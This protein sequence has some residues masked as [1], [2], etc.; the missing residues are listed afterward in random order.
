MGDVVCHVNIEHGLK[1]LRVHS[2]LRLVNHS[3]LALEG[4]FE[5]PESEQSTAFE[6]D[7]GD[8]QFAP[9]PMIESGRVKIF[10][11]GTTETVF[12][13]EL[14]ALCVSRRFETLKFQ[15]EDLDCF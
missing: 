8:S 2:I 4:V 15:H 6:F 5:A 14:R 3:S 1:I 10:V 9:L 11:R 12:A 13:D 7:C